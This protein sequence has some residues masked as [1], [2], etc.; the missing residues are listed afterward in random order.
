MTYKRNYSIMLFM[1]FLFLV[2]TAAFADFSG[3][4]A[5]W[6]RIFI[7]Y[8]SFLP[9]LPSHSTNNIQPH[10]KAFFGL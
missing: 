3:K 10:N 4:V 9:E 5:R 8:K 7:L 6:G 1:T 2:W